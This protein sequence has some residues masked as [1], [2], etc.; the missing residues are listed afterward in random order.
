[1]RK[2]FLLL[3]N[4]GDGSHGLQ[5]QLNQGDG[6]PGL[7]ILFLTNPEFKYSVLLFILLYNSFSDKCLPLFYY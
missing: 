6:S 7:L 4:Q 1:M 3:V 2:R 5:L